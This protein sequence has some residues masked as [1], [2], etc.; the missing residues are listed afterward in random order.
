MAKRYDQK[1]K[2]EV[3]SFIKEY[4]DENGRGGQAAAAKKWDLNPITVKSWM[5]KAGVKSPGKTARK[6]KGKSGRKPGRP[7]GSSVTRR[8]PVTG[9]SVSGTLKKMMQL[10]EKIEVLQAE[11]NALKGTI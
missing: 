8:A 6:K 7:A 2:D 10:Q 4:N 5:E 9:D 3:V 11:Y 1:T